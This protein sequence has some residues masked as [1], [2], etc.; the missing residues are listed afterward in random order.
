MDNIILIEFLKCVVKTTEPDCL[1]TATMLKL[2]NELIKKTDEE[3]KAVLAN[4]VNESEEYKYAALI[5]IVDS[6]ERETLDKLKEDLLK[7]YEKILLHIT[8]VNKIHDNIQTYIPINIWDDFYEDGYVPE[9]KIQETYAY[10]EDTDIPHEKRKEYLS[11]LV[12]HILFNNLL[13]NTEVKL[14]FH[15]TKNDYDEE[16]IKKGI[17]M[18]GEDFFFKRWEIKFKNLSHADLNALMKSLKTDVLAHDDILLD[19]YS[20]S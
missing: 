7:D 8:Q 6:S 5:A 15:D 13:P 20:E 11:M 17:E 10:V 16:R 14:D 1:E 4:M 19:I 3:R 18:Y 2:Y 12:E 9:G